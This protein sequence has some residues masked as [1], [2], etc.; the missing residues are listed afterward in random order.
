MAD[1]ITQ[2][3]A[4][5]P[6]LAAC[7]REPTPITPVWF[8]RQAGRYMPEYRALRE[9]Y[10]LLEMMRTPEIAVQVTLLPRRLGVDALI[11]FADILL[12]LDAMGMGLHF[13]PGKGPVLERPVRG[14]ADVDRLRPVNV[15]E[16]LGYVL[17]TVRG[18]RAEVGDRVPLIGF[19][20]APFTLASYAVE[21]G[22]SRYY[23]RTKHLMYADP[24]TWHRFMQHLADVTLAYLRAQVEAGAHAVQLFDSWAG[25]LSPADYRTYV[26][27]HT[28][29]IFTGLADLGIPRIYFATGAAGMLPLFREVGADV[30]GVDWRIDLDRAWALLGESVAIQGNLDPVALFAP[31]DVLARQV[32]RVL[33]QAAGRP[34]HIFN[35]GHGILPETP[36]DNVRFVVDFVHEHTTQSPISNL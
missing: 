16:D 36:V 35:L 26:L 9:R 14:P 18:V 5:A 11:L 13:V 24:A 6:F 32:Q 28:R 15:Q 30:V 10:G 17:A 3:T 33:S 27:P 20:G 29:R 4:T 31:R 21:G 12:P 22:A 19:A 34:G 7:R 8:M 2:T 23:V 25:A 1:T